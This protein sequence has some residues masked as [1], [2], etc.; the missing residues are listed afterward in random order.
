M[1]IAEAVKGAGFGELPILPLKFSSAFD[2]IFEREQSIAQ[3]CG[4]DP[5]LKFSFREVALQFDAI[6]KH[7]DEVENAKQK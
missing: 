6:Y 5:L 1:N 2:A 7:I 3:I 4:S